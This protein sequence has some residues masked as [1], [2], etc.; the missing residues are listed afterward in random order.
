MA[1]PAV[2]DSIWSPQVRQITSPSKLSSYYGK[3]RRGNLE[4]DRHAIHEV[5]VIRRLAAPYNGIHKTP[6][7]VSYQPVCTG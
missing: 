4:R 1:R 2:V 6:L 5:R 7:L 3:E